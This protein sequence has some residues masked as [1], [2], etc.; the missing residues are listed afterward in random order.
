MLSAIWQWAIHMPGLLTSSKILI[1]SPVVWAPCPSKQGFHLELHFHR[2]QGSVVHEKWI[3]CCM[4]WSESSSFSIS[5]KTLSPSSKSQSISSINSS[6]FSINDLPVHNVITEHGI[7]S[8]PSCPPIRFQKI[9]QLLHRNPH[10]RAIAHFGDRAFQTFHDP[11][12][13]RPCHQFQYWA[14]DSYRIPFRSSLSVLV[15]HPVFVCFFLNFQRLPW[16]NL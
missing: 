16:W 6:R 1:V 7:P 9:H 2:A 13:Y 14:W 4:G 3:G 15:A 8:C 10:P 11:S 5:I 12:F